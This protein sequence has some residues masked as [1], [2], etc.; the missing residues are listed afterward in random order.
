MAWKFPRFKLFDSKP[1]AKASA[2]TPSS[3][4]TP[5]TQATTQEPIRTRSERP[6]FFGEM[7]SGMLK[8]SGKMQSREHFN[9]QPNV[10][11]QQTSQDDRYHQRFSE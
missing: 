9:H 2:D 8:G 7:F 11:Q 3:Q 4:S 5:T 6:S 10:V 1:K